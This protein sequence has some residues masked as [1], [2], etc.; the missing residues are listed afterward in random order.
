MALTIAELAAAL[1]AEW[2]GQGDCQVGRASEPAAAGPGDL[3]LAMDKSYGDALSRG[4]ARAAV[5]W[6][7]ADWRALGLTAAIFVPR[8]RYAMAGITAAF[9]LEPDLAAGIHA[10]AI[11]DPTAVIGENVAVG[12]YSIIGAGATIGANARILGQVTIA[13]L[14]R[15]GE[16][17]L[18]F[19]GVRI[20][21]RVSVGRRFIAHGNAVI[22]SDGF[23]FV[24]P[25]PSG[26]E[27]AR[28]NFETSG[29]ARP[30]AYAKIASNASVRIG[31]DVEIGANSTIDRGTVADTVIGRGTKIDNLVQVGHNVRIGQDCLL[32]AQ[33]AIAGSSVLGDRVVLGGQSGVGDHLTLGDDVIAAGAT[34][35]LS[36]V[37]TG[38]VMMGYPAMKMTQNIAAYKA[39]RRLPRLLARFDD[40]Q[41]RVSKHDQKP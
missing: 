30:Q 14:A 3:A 2:V 9:A 24:T 27:E 38:R 15:I 28:K 20:G 13:E 18:I 5:L 19:S 16:D 26:A 37:P 34:A 39:L 33:A 41:K 29:E 17:A 8:P 23:S 1:G 35:I 22:G 25:E 10:T 6:P 32:C 7:G 40:L 12:A 11:I 21:A 31:D 36:N 4:G